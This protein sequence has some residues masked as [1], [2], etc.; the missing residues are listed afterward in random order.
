MLQPLDYVVFFIY[1]VIVACYGLWIYNRK[2][3]KQTSSKDY[4]LAEGSLTW[5]AIGASLIASNI[6][7]E[8]MIGMS[9]SG[10][11][12]GLAISTYEWMAAATLVIVAVFFIPVYLKNKIYTMPQFL[13][14]RYNGTVAMIMAIFWLAL[15]IVVNLMSILYLG[16]LAISSISGI[17]VYTCIALLAVFAVVITLGGMK[18]IGYTDV[19]QVFFLILGG[20]VATYIALHLVAAKSGQTGLVNGFRI[21]TSTASDHFHMIFKKDSPNYVSLPGLSVLIG[22]MWITNLNYWG[23]NQ[24][25]TQRALGADLK[26]ARSGILFAAFLKLLMPVIVVLPGIGAYVLYQ[27]GMFHAGMLSHTGAVDVN[28][29]YPNLMTVLPEGFKGIAFAALTAAIVA[30]LA[31]KANSIATIFTLDIYKKAI[32]KEADESKLVITGKIAVIVSMLLAVLMSLVIGEKLMGEGK[33]GFNYIQEY[34]G[35]VSPGIL[36][37]F[38]LGFFWKR[39]TANAAMFAMIGGLA[40]SIIFKFLPMWA[41]LSWLTPYGFFQPN[42]DNH[43]VFEIPFLDRMGFVFLICIAGMAIIN[44]VENRRGVV[45]KGLIVDTSMFKVSKGFA[46]GAMVIVAILITLYTVY[47]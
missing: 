27:K 9:G 44:F 35:F 26:T 21:M 30:S 37:M 7:A 3:A 36:A 32:N 2:K 33:Q 6:S 11:R 8:Q 34:T 5:W 45:T 19:I 4:F 22:G 28:K 43:G 47:W 23:C 40:L 39:T 16:A 20:L 15:Y 25:I 1:F 46:I 13:N 18:V 41:D 14:Q 10:F 17:S 24:Y 42:P 29:A 38:L 31:G 12:L